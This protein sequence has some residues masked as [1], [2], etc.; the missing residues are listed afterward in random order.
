MIAVPPDLTLDGILA[1]KNAARIP[2]SRSAVGP[3]FARHGFIFKKLYAAGQRAPR[4]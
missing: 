3:F 2:G 4:R 1:A